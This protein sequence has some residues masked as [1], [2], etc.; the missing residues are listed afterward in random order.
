MVIDSRKTP[1]SHTI[2][3]RG[4]TLIAVYKED[5]TDTARYRYFVYWS[6]ILSFNYKVKY[7]VKTYILI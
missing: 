4:Y 1:A 6:K 3:Q 5:I 7:S 2:C